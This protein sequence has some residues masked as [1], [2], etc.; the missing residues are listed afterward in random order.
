[1]NSVELQDVNAISDFFFKPRYVEKRISSFLSSNFTTKYT[2]QLNL[3]RGIALKYSRC[4]ES[5]HIENIN[6][7]I[8]FM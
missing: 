7:R 1:M 2:V 3:S 5:V 8:Y 4:K 6:K